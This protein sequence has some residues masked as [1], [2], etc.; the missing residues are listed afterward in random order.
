[1]EDINKVIADNIGLVYTGL[2]KFYL[3]NDPDAESFAYEALW[4]A[5]QTYKT[6]EGT[7]FSTYAMVCILNAL[8]CHVRRLNKKNKLSVIS[9]NTIAY[10][11]G[12][13][14]H[15]HMEFLAVPGAIDDNIMQE[16]LVDKTRREIQVVYA[17]LSDRHKAIVDLYLQRDRK[18]VV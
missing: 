2:K 12:T 18:S 4:R 17:E 10:T 16:E 5:A 14:S 1:M 3:L 7:V 8:G 13:E 6:D 11:D 15:E 9:Y